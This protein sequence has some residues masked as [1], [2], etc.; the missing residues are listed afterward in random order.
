[1]TSM[2]PLIRCDLSKRL[3]KGRKTLKWLFPKKSLKMLSRTHDSDNRLRAVF[4]GRS[5]RQVWESN[6][7]WSRYFRR[8]GSGGEGV[9]G[10]PSWFYVVASVAA[11]SPLCVMRVSRRW[12]G[13]Q[14]L[15]TSP[16]C[17]M[18]ELF[19][20]IIGWD[21][22]LEYAV[23]AATVAN[24]WSGYFQSV[25]GK[26][27]ISVMDISCGRPAGCTRKLSRGDCRCSICPPWRLWPS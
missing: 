23:G 26:F 19:A 12:R 20:W 18:G 2:E 27:G 14:A 17:T 1:M 22:V 13:A 25:L 6:G 5:P 15:P 8:H 7:D 10:Q 21:L 16:Y 4:S 3:A 9:A 24:G 11:S